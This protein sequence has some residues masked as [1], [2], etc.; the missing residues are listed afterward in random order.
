MLGKAVLDRWLHWYRIMGCCRLGLFGCNRGG[1]FSSFNVLFHTNSIVLIIFLGLQKGL[2]NNYIIWS[3]L[4]TTEID[5]LE[6][7]FHACM[8]WQLGGIFTCI[9]PFSINFGGRFRSCHDT[10]YSPSPLR[11]WISPFVCLLWLWILNIQYHRSKIQFI[12]FYTRV[13]TTSV[14]ASLPPLICTKTL[15]N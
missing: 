13:E 4:A 12:L 6:P 9:W 8:P 11:K 7:G 5:V 1:T 2:A 10:S 15:L 14:C 3:D